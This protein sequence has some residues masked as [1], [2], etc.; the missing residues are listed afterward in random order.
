M[1]DPALR[2]RLAW[3]LAAGRTK[4][5][6]AL[7]EG[8]S[9]AELAEILATPGIFAVV[10]AWAMFLVERDRSDVTGIMGLVRWALDHVRAH[11]RERAVGPGVGYALMIGLFLRACWR[12]TFRS[13]CRHIEDV[14]AGNAAPRRPLRGMRR[15]LVDVMAW[16]IE[17]AIIDQMT[18]QHGTAK[19]RAMDEQFRKAMASGELSTME[20]QAAPGA[21]VAPEDLPAANSATVEPPLPVATRTALPPRSL[22]HDHHS[23]SPVVAPGAGLVVLLE[24][25]VRF[26]RRRW[27]LP[28]SVRPRPI[29]RAA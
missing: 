23:R 4:P 5:E 1:A 13:L 22:V 9:A 25:A 10:N 2:R 28:P 6:I 24:D 17:I 27:R 15:Q 12:G 8:M 14:I 7:A 18:L 19:L 20:W 3:G 29:G 16:A 21:A 26:K 11:A